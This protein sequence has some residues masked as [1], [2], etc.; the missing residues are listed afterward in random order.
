MA[1]LS[2]LEVSEVSELRNEARAFESHATEVKRTTDQMLELIEQSKSIW[3]GDAASRFAA[4]F[5]GLQ[6]DMQKIYD[7]CQEYS[8][9]LIQIA[10]N[11]ERSE[12]DNESTA[13][14]LKADV[15]LRI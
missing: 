9:D 3:R 10:D 7:M 14:R 12:T 2:A 11:Y 1:I 8:T 6:D 5:A 4:Q 13:S 15:E